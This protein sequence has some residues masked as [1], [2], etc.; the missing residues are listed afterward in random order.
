[1]KV[2]LAFAMGLF[3]GMPA[4]LIASPLVGLLLAAMADPKEGE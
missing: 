1:M 2:M 3:W 4:V